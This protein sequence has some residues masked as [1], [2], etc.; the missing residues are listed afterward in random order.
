AVG[1]VFLGAATVRLGGKAQKEADAVAKQAK[2]SGDQ[3][4]L[5]RQQLEASQQPFVLPVTNDWEPL[6]KF[7]MER[8]I[9]QGMGDPWEPWMMLTNA[10]AGPAINVTG[11]SSGTEG[12]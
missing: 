10:G 6:M 5:T 8:V 1:T 12:S 9:P 7:P 2:L 3:L 4:D 11:A